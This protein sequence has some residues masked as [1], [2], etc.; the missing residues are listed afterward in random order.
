M[1]NKIEAYAKQYIKQELNNGIIPDLRAPDLVKLFTTAKDNVLFEVENNV[2]YELYHGAAG[3][4]L[5]RN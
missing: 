2:A 1:E 3:W 5:C 4:R